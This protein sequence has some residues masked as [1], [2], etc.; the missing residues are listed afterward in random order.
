LR[1]SSGLSLA[2]EFSFPKTIGLPYI[3]F[4]S[5]LSLAPEFSFPNEEVF[6]YMVI[7]SR[8]SL[9]SE[10]SFPKKEGLPYIVIPS[11]ISLA[12]W[13]TSQRLAYNL[14]TITPIHM[15]V[16]SLGRFSIAFPMAFVPGGISQN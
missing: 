8:L 4:P 10:F 12:L 6:P 2:L 16:V 15:K 9:A 5:D 13:G 11:E 3:V 1:G 7:P 14:A